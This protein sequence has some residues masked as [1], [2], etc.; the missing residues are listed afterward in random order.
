[1]IDN[2][3]HDI[4]V[5]AADEV[6]WNEETMLLVATRFIAGLGGEDPNILEKLEVYLQEQV[7]E[8]NDYAAEQVTSRATAPA[9]AKKAAARSS[10]SKP[11]ATSAVPRPR[12]RS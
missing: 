1:M 9:A 8:E 10:R 4:L 12:R 5:Q 2:A 11:R 3:A 6:G 7:A